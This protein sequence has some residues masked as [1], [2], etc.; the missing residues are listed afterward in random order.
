MTIIM[1]T[2]NTYEINGTKKLVAQ[3]K[4]SKWYSYAPM[5]TITSLQ[6]EIKIKASGQT[7][8]IKASIQ[9]QEL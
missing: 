8:K 7:K 1:E 6:D 4:V 2:A 3:M 5:I 9:P